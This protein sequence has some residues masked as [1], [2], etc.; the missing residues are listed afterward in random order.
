MSD[1][2]MYEVVDNDTGEVVRSHPQKWCAS[3]WARSMNVSEGRVR[4][5]MRPANQVRRV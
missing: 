3:Y 1:N 4:Y 2:R 5:T